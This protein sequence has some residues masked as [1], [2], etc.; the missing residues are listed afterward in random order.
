MPYYICLEGK[1]IFSLYF[2]RL[3]IN[4]VWYSAHIVARI[5]ES[6][7]LCYQT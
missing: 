7:T 4:S 2:H 5:I 1:L 6:R 3:P